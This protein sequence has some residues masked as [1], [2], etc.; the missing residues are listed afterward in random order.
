MNILEKDIEHSWLFDDTLDYG[1]LGGGCRVEF[2]STSYQGSYFLRQA[3]VTAHL[4]L[5][6]LVCV[7]PWCFPVNLPLKDVLC[8]PSQRRPEDGDPAAHRGVARPHRSR[9]TQVDL[10][11]CFGKVFN[12]QSFGQVRFCFT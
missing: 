12:R 4:S 3:E 1:L 2:I 9:G 7:L 11:I 8:V 5:K 10:R 6:G